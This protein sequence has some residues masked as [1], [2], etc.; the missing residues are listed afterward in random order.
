MKRVIIE[1]PLSGDFERN[2]RYARLCM[3]DSLQRGEAPF[4]SHL[5]YTQV[6]NDLDEEL[7]ASG[8]AAAQAWYPAADLCAV[9]IDL[10]ISGGMKDG[11]AVCEKCP[12]GI[13]VV[14]RRLEVELMS[15]FW[16]MQTPAAT[17]GA[18]QW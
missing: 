2:I 10:D 9:Y 14:Q 11:I 3:L 12:G 15:Q 7:R 4:A 6:W 5:L 1:S 13:P 17:P 18:S 8:M 16:N